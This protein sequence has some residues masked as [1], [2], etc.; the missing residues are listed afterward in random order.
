[1]PYALE[2]D[3]NILELIHVTQA[4]TEILYSHIFQCFV[5]ACTTRRQNHVIIWTSKVYCKQLWNWSREVMIKNLKRNLCK[6]HSGV[7]RECL[8]KMNVELQLY[9]RAHQRSV[10][11]VNWISEKSA[12]LLRS[13]L[14][15]CHRQKGNS[16]P[17]SRW[18]ETA[19]QV[20]KES[21]VLL[22]VW[23]WNMWYS[24]QEWGWQ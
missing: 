1:M 21:W 24:Y 10:V 12:G 22:P 23:A 14:V 3:R 16:T 18:P 4:R 19:W 15:H 5:T 6:W 8:G 13:E 9:F 11:V 2:L 20:F 17:G 7:E